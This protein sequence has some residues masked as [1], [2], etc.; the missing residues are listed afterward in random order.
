MNFLKLN[1]E[2]ADAIDRLSNMDIFDNGIANEIERGKAIARLSKS[3]ISNVALALEIEKFKSERNIKSV[4]IPKIL[5]T[6]SEN[7]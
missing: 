6:G 1:N 3:Q 5:E 2:I 7:E 4:D